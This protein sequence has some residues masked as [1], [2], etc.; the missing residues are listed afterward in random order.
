MST[1]KHFRMGLFALAA[2]SALAM[3]A[4]AQIPAPCLG[5]TYGASCTGIAPL[6]TNQ[7]GAYSKGMISGTMAAGLA[8]N[9]PVYS[10]RY[11]GTGL[12]VVKQIRISAANAGTGFAVGVGNF[13][14]Y[15][16][17]AFTASD[18]G[19]TAGTLTNNNGDLRTAFPAMG[20]SDIRIAS[21][22]TLTAGTRTLGTDALTNLMFPTSATASISLVSPAVIYNI[23]PG[24]YPMVLTNNEGFVIQATVP[25]TGTWT[26]TVTVDWE[27]YT[28]F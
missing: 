11:G 19:G 14:L 10:F 3:P 18:T 6:T 8:A 25:A 17:T 27:E 4:L 24:D 12:A 21:T 9:S 7:T 23:P 1:M 15:F 2:M 26:F 13:S 16:A 20:V 22:A 28:G 5:G